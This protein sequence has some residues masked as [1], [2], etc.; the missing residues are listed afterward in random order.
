MKQRCRLLCRNGLFALAV[1]VT[2]PA[3]AGAQSTD[4]TVVRGEIRIVCPLTV[5]GSFEGRSAAVSGTLAQ[6]SPTS[7]TFAG[8]V[9]LDLRT[10]DTGIELRNRHMKDNYLEVTKAAGFEDAVLTELVL[11]DLDP[12][13][14]SGKARFTGQISVHGVRKPVSGAADIRVSGNTARV[15]TKFPFRLPDHEIV[16][17]RYLGVGVKDEIQILV[18]LMLEAKGTKE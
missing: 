17:P 8:E 18:S 12:T 7:S 3:L 14:P 16:S 9:R 10:L 13:R 2:L 15:E 4:W 11:S 5:G 1:F 6:P